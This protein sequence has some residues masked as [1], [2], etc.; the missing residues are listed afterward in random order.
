MSLPCRSTEPLRRLAIVGAAFLAF[1]SPVAA[2]WP[3]QLRVCSDPNNLPFS[4][5]KEEGFENRIAA[6][7][8]HDLGVPL[9]YIWLP[10]RRGLVRNTLTAGLC[11]VLMGVPA[12]LERVA[13]TAPYY[14]SSYVLV[15]PADL[16][17][18]IDSLDDPA[19]PSLRIG[20]QLVGDDE[21]N[22]PPV[23]ALNRRGMVDNLRGYSIYGD[24]S[25]AAPASGIVDA[26]ASGEVDVALVWGPI[27]GYF[28]KAEPRP[29]RL[30]AVTGESELPMAFSVAISVRRA[31]GELRDRLDEALTRNRT[32]ID[33]IL[34]S[35]GVPLLPVHD[36]PDA[37]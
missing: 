20:V 14:R 12:D 1:A 9:T 37:R 18:P 6:M 7:L 34:A 26:V 33:A 3:D 30:A 10:L 25:K 28:A 32:A 2:A 5:Q 23:H 11:D 17:H 36:M 15:M 13:T 31:D 19:L 35:Y 8:V 16:G 4:D 29:L 24:Y 27:A 21:A 22:T